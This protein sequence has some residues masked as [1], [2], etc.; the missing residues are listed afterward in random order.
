MTKMGE[1]FTKR[2]ASATPICGQPLVYS[3]FMTGLRP[4]ER[5]R[6]PIYCPA[7]HYVC[8]HVTVKALDVLRQVLA[9]ANLSIRGYP[10][11]VMAHPSIHAQA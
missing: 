7:G 2:L 9:T 10:E 8:V 1:P 6:T 11:R 3:T 4:L 5:G